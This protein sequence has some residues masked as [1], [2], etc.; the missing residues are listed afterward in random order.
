[1]R[2]IKGSGCINR[3]VC[4]ILSDVIMMYNKL[5]DIGR[6]STKAKLILSTAVN[7]VER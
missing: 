1:M 5:V 3:T 7:Y 4:C 2:G 6:K